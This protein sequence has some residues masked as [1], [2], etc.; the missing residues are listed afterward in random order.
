MEYSTGVYLFRGWI[1]GF[2]ASYVV[3]YLLSRFVFNKLEVVKAFRLSLGFTFLLLIMVS[4]YSLR[5][6]LLFYTPAVLNIFIIETLRLTR[7][8]CP[9]CSRRVKKDAAVCGYCGQSL[10]AER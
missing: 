5:E 4:E 10:V 8:P 3:Y 7:K 1:G 6:A 9:A 2:I